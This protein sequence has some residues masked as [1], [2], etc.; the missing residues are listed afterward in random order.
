MG[1]EQNCSLMLPEPCNY[2]GRRYS[3]A[4]GQRAAGMLAKSLTSHFSMSCGYSTTLKHEAHVRCTE[5]VGPSEESEVSPVNVVHHE[6]DTHVPPSPYMEIQSDSW[7]L[8][9]SPK[10][11]HG[12]KSLNIEPI[13]NVGPRGKECLK[14]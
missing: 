2:S 6:G 4:R 3:P 5:Q 10:K 1:R 12:Q 9:T 14:A 7:C 13:S 8:C 11:R